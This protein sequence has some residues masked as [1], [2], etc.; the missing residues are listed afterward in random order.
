MTKITELP[1]SKIARRGEPHFLLFLFHDSFTAAA[2]QFELHSREIPGL[3]ETHGRAVRDGSA[4]SPGG[5]SVLLSK[6]T[7]RSD[8]GILVGPG[9]SVGWTSISQGIVQGDP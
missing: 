5:D 1:V 6:A 3:S 7:A 2:V 4:V 8:V 9:A